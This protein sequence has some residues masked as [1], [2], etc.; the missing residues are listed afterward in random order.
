MLSDCKFCIS[1][2]NENNY[3]SLNVNQII[4]DFGNDTNCYKNCPY[5]YYFDL[6]KKYDCALYS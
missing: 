1:S 5:F 2:G 3:N 6:D 4:N